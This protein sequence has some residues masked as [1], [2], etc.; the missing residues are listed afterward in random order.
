MPA[1]TDSFRFRDLHPNVRVGTASDRYAGW[2]GQIY[3]PKRYEGR[4]QQRTNRVGGRPF[5]E[6]V[7]PVDSVEEYFEHFSVLEIDYT[8][9]RPLL[10]PDGRPSSNYRVLARYAGHLREDDRLIL[11]VPQAVCA[12]K[13]RRGGAHVPNDSYLDPDLFT[14]RFYEPAVELLGRRLGGFIFEQEYQRKQDRIPVEELASGL[15]TFFGAIPA[16][17]RYHVELRTESYLDGPLFEVLERHGVGRV[18]SHWTWLPPLAR[19]LELSGG[20]FLSGAGE[21]VVRLMTPL[22]VRYADAYARAHPFDRLVE[23]LL[24]ARMVTETVSVLRA[25]VAQGGTMNLVINNRSGGNAP[26]IAQTIAE[27]FARGEA[28]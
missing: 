4:I 14:R 27:A 19:Q 2:L 3:S 28:R 1:D 26:M 18:L 22:G 11:K 17:G 9:Y 15:D 10:E 21:C 20:R 23:G 24:Q 5:I 6:K 7:L 25:G 13:L 8:F 16:D 12:Q